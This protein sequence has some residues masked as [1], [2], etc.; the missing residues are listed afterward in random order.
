[1]KISLITVCLNSERTILDS[2]NSVKSQT[3]KNIEH[4]FVDGG[5]FDNTLSIIN[6]HK[7]INAK[8]LSEKD[9][10]IGAINKGIKM[11]EGDIIGI[12]NSDDVL[13]SKKLI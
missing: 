2:I 11:A 10:G 5:S 4:I 7:S 6:R 13:F 8:I 3:Y 9:N 1:M 12:I